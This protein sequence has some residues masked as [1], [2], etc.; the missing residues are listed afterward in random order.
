MCR[1]EKARILFTRVYLSVLQVVSIDIMGLPKLDLSHFQGPEDTFMSS[2]WV[3]VLNSMYPTLRLPLH[4]TS[5]SQNASFHSPWAMHKEDEISQGTLEWQFNRRK[6][7]GITLLKNTSK[8]GLQ[9]LCMSLSMQ[10]A[11]RLWQKLG[12]GRGGRKTVFQF[13]IQSDS[14]QYSVFK[15]FPCLDCCLLLCG[16]S[17]GKKK[18]LH[19]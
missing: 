18:F 14:S 10:N 3:P 17:T 16:C 19:N 9:L 12:R 1:F 4:L 11:S 8:Q 5:P 7:S 13:H 2:V 15:L 6:K